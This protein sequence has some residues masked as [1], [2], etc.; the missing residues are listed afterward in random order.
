MLLT[1]K[2]SYFMNSSIKT[3]TQLRLARF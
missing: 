2:I 1:E 3:Q